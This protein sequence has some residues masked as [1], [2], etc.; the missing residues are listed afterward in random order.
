MAP[1]AGWGSAFRIRYEA[2]WL[3]ADVLSGLSI[4]AV[5]LPSAIA[6]PAIAGLPPQVGLHSSMVPLLGYALFGSSR[7]LIVGPDAGTTIVLA[8]VLASFAPTQGSNAATVAAAIAATVGL[9]CFLAS[10]LRLGVV[11]NFLSRP[12][13]IGFISGISV[14]ILVGQI[15]RFTGVKVASDG[16]VGPILEIARRASEIHWPTLLLAGSLLVLLRVL[17]ARLPA[18]PGPL[19]AIALATALSM[20]F[21]LPGHGIAVIGRIPSELPEFSLPIRTGVPLDELVLGAG[22]VLLVSF[23][24]GIVTARSFAA[25][26]KE[27]IDANRE[28]VGFGAA[29]IA[30][31]LFGGFPITASNS[32]TAVNLSMGGKTQLAGVVAAVSLM[33]AV[34]FLDK[35]LSFV[36]NA[37][38]GAVLAS[39][40]LSLIDV[41][42]FRTL[43]RTSRAEFLFAVVGMVGAIGLGVLQGVVVAVAATLVYLLYRG[44]A[45]RDAVLGRI[46]GREGVLRCSHKVAKPIP[47]MTLW[48]F[49]GSLL[50]VNAEHVKERLESLVAPMPAGSWFILDATAIADIDSTAAAMLDDMLSLFA[51]K[52][53]CFGIAEL[54]SDPMGLLERSGVL[55]RS[56]GTWYSMTSRTPR[57]PS[58]TVSEEAEAGAREPW[59]LADTPRLRDA[60]RLPPARLLF[61][62][63]TERFDGTKQPGARRQNDG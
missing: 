24:S 48:L 14:S 8:G 9:L 3:R 27:Q 11:A 1:F 6:Y 49:Q 58:S 18:L 22:A 20:L 21:D 47:G 33:L 38:L 17:A 29:N 16:L 28:L 60:T 59:Q 5:G 4:A 56:A 15:G 40:A 31:G 19:V 12:I 13:L 43:W 62:R 44:L 63:S 10:L 57:P 53:V 54:N 23:G 25:R 32:R 36:P 7:H 51:A 34:L 30:A 50:F 42:A 52:G 35:P 39:A 26:A 55:D 46:A 45:P 2:K 37:A 41:E 61:S